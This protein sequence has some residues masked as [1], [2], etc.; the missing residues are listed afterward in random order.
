M[1]NKVYLFLIMSVV[2]LLFMPFVNSLW[3]GK[4]YHDKEFFTKAHLFNVDKVLSVV[5]LVLYKIG[6]STDPEQVVIGRN[7]WL[8]LGDKYAN[9]ITVSRMGETEKT[10]IDT[11][12]IVRMVKG[13][14]AWLKKNGVMT[15][16]V[17]IG[18]NK[19]SIYSE[20][21]PNWT[22]PAKKSAVDGLFFNNSVYIDVREELKSTK[23]TVYYKTDT[24]W[25][26]YGAGVAFKKLMQESK[27]E[28]PG[29]KVLDDKSY[30]VYSVSRRDGGDLSRFLKIDKI[31]SDDESRVNV[32]N[33]SAATKIYDYSTGKLIWSGNGLP[34]IDASEKG[35]LILSTNALNNKKVLW[36]SDSFGTSMQP[37][38]SATFSQVLKFHWAYV[39]GSSQFSELVNK[40]KPD[41]VF[42]TSV[43]R[44]ARSV[45]FMTRPPYSIQ[46]LNSIPK[47]I[48][49]T[50]AIATNDLRQVGVRYENNGADPYIIYE[51]KK[52]VFID[53]VRGVNVFLNCH[54]MKDKSNVPLQLF[55]MI[56][57]MNGFDEQNSIRFNVVSRSSKIDLSN[58]PEWRV[59]RRVNKIRLDIDTY[60]KCLKFDSNISLF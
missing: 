37:F 31:I 53:E 46:A 36:L 57:G 47:A 12:E 29:L 8:Y 11:T 25:N 48:Y 28:W 52:P 14:D 22:L 33:S 55:W 51:L 38:M 24:H 7:G 40:W 18:P 4:D 6:V 58:Q 60:D 21:L 30:Q 1:K 16:R 17:L 56:D 32:Q 59:K 9:S 15:F 43:E 45:N 39:V 41:F 54:E 5:N 27:K 10:I 3:G 35:K 34:L 50:K 19:D 42:I 13:W 2:G 23:P 26:V 20:N 44:D 49:E